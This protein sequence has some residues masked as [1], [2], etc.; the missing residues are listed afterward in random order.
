MLRWNRISGAAAALLT[1]LIA[2]AVQAGE[3]SSPDVPGRVA[4]LIAF[5]YAGDPVATD[6]ERAFNWAVHSDA[7]ELAIDVVRANSSYE[8]ALACDSLMAENSAARLIVFAGDEGAAAAV[9]L[10]SA[11]YHMPVLKLTSDPRSFVRF[12]NSLYEFLPSMELQSQRLAEYAARDLHLPTAVTLTP[13]DAR[14]RALRDG[15]RHGLEGL[16]AEL[17]SQRFYPSEALEVRRDAAEVFSDRSRL[18]KGGKALN[19]ALSQDERAAMFGDSQQ[20]EVLFSTGGRDSITTPPVTGNEAFFFGIA[21]G[22]VD[23]Y[24]QQIPALPAGTLLFGNS[25]W[26]DFEA[27]SRQQSV[28]DGMFMS[29]P[30]LPRVADPD[31]YW[32]AYEQD[33]NHDATDWERL[34]LDAG[35]YVSRIM[36]GHPRARTDVLRRLAETPFTGRAVIVEYAGS[37]ENR[38]VRIVR[39]ENRE[40]RLVR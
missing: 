22:K 18:E 19:A 32:D 27:L 2:V 29:V 39:F 5:S 9:A 40:L 25:S 24:A 11:E 17:L 21:P 6:I 15:F 37:R 1:L 13:E 23:P 35:H 28:T 36:T 33:R 30:L 16:K 3:K 31:V 38:A 26:L 14:G 7:S 12:S 34:G 20:G 10:M 8:A 4:L